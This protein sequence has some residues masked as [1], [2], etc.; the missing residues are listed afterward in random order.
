MSSKE[1]ESKDVHTN[2]EPVKPEQEQNW[3]QSSQENQKL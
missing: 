1:F 2:L 3:R